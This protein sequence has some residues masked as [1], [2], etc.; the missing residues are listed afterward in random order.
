MFSK[1]YWLPTPNLPQKMLGIMPRPRGNDWLQDEIR[2]LKFR[3]VDIVVSLLEF[4]EIY[5]LE[6]EE[7]GRIC[8]EKDIH[9]I[10][11][12]IEDI[13]VPKDEKQ[14]FELIK[15]LVECLKNN[16][17]IVIHCRMGIGR[18]SVVAA[19]ILIKL[20]TPIA[21]VFDCMSKARGLAVPDTEEQK[22]WILSR[23]WKLE[24]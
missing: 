18:S 9:F 1:I 14:Y 22:Q 20:G 7:E 3:Q 19:G 5:E 6:L 24:A 15:K 23:N 16:N 11:F 21:N 2:S 12:P 4:G 10:N 13:H 17:K 8:S